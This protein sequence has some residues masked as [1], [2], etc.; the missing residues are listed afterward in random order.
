MKLPNR[1]RA[2]RIE[3]KLTQ[4]ELAQK[5]G[6]KS[7]S[8]INKIELGISDITQSKVLEFAKA[9]N[10][11]PEYLMGW[12]DNVI[13]Q[14]NRESKLVFDMRRPLEA[15]DRLKNLP[16]DD[17]LIKDYLSQDEN[18]LICDYRTLNNAGQKKTQEYVTDL[19]STEKYTRNSDTETQGS[20]TPDLIETLN[21]P[22]K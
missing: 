8:S 6:Y 18:K 22:Y 14:N 3:L 4:S 19:K 7:R 21:K 20:P 17:Y 15:I 2:R 9:L 11:S 16:D 13:S 12:E 5:L 10:C 1:I